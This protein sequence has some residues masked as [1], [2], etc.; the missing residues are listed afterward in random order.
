MLHAQRSDKALIVQ[1]LCKTF[2]DNRSVNYILRQDRKKAQRLSHL[3]AYAFE[4]CSRF[5]E[6]YLSED[7]KACALLLFPERKKGSLVS[8]LLDLQLVW[9]SIGFE[10]LPKKLARERKLKPLYPQKPFFYLWLIGVDP[11]VQHQGVGRNLLLQV[12]NRAD[13]LQRPIYLETSA[14]KNV[15]WYQKFGFVLYKEI[16]FT[17]DLFC[18]YRPNSGKNS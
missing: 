12:I 16:S 7:R 1:L 17:Y 14:A 13:D 3:M 8:M 6:V 5:G 2:E 4:V 11:S 18:L 15:G 10:N 9:Q